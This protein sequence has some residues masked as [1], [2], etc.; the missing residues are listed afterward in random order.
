MDRFYAHSS[1]SGV[2]AVRALGW[3]ITLIGVILLVGGVWLV[4]LGGSAYYL[5]AG[6]ALIASGALI[7]MQRT[8]GGGRQAIC[9]DHGRRSSFHADADQRRAGRLCAAIRLMAADRHP[10]GRSTQSSICMT[11]SLGGARI[12]DAG[13]NQPTDQIVWI[14]DGRAADIEAARKTHKRRAELPACAWHPSYDMAAGAAI[15]DHQA[16]RRDGIHPRA[17][18]FSAKDIE[19]GWRARRRTSAN[20]IR[21][22]NG[23]R[24][25]HSRSRIG[26]EPLNT[27]EGDLSF[28][29]GCSSSVRK[30]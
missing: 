26:D 24:P 29:L 12:D 10:A 8:S 17:G 9:G 16:G 19:S 28:Q 1:R 2:W 13:I 25:D 30:K 20:A 5:V 11:S 3:I 27:G 6:A 21:L 23:S 14:V 15:A 7:A 22:D 18:S 4:S